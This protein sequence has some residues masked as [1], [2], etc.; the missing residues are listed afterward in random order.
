MICRDVVIGS[1]LESK[2]GFSVLS[3][4]LSKELMTQSYESGKLWFN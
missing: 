1:V 3:K 4:S 2:T